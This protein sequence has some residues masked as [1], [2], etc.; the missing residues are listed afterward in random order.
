MDAAAETFDY[1]I[2]GSGGGSMCAALVVR[3]MGKSAL[4]LEKTSLFGGTTARS[5]GVMWI[6]NNSLMAADGLA[7]SPEKALLYLDHVVGDHDDAPGATRARRMAYVAEA[8]RMLDFLIEQGIKLHRYPYWPDYYDDYPGGLEQGRAVIADLFDAN[9]LG[10]AKAQLRPNYVPAPAKPEEVMR[11]PLARTT[12][13]GKVAQLKI[14]LR[15]LTSKLTGRH[16]VT[17]GA[18]L[19]GRMFQAALRVGVDMRTNTPVERLVTDSTGRITG[20]VARIDGAPRTFGARFGVLV[21]AGGFARNQAMRDQ[22]QPGSS[23]AWSNTCEGDTGE[24]IL[25]MMRV[26][27]AVGQMDA[28]AGQQVAIP[29]EKREVLP[30][31]Q[32]ELAKPHSIVVDQ[33]GVRYIREAQSYMSFCQEMFAR[34]KI[35]PAVPSWAVFDEQYMSKYMVA[36][37]LPGSKKPQSWYDSGFLIEADT[38]RELATLCKMDPDKL[39]SSVTRFNELARKGK[40]ED[41]HRGDRAYDRFLGDRAHGPSPTLGTIEKGPFYAYRVYPGDIGTFGGVVTDVNARVLREDGSAIPGLYATGTS[42]A[43][44]MG[45]TYPG[46]GCSVGPS[47]VWGY[48]AAKH[49]MSATGE[50]SEAGG[51]RGYVTHMSRGS[52][53]RNVPNTA[54][55]AAAR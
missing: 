31:V 11:I 13:A 7:E 38:L 46:P 55:S 50:I 42:T 10:P 4:I 6:P 41:L 24:M 43:A 19:Q 34:D 12:W 25:E 5:G 33:S 27:A 53:A 28:I 8:P 26:G 51:E 49:A 2:I 44:V 29:P 32:P 15:M 23:A 21:N 1:I 47:F 36:E 54:G 18:A 20:V 16:W 14:G 3:S 35:V 40:D 48:V 52:A 39:A 37:T 9:E 22:Y 17:F 30:M 45:R